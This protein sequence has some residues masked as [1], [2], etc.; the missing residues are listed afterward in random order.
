MPSLFIV[1]LLIISALNGYF[2]IGKLL[3]YRH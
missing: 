2:S 1:V 3:L